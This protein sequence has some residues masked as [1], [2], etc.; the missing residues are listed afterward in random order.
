MENKTIGCIRYFGTDVKPKYDFDESI[1]SEEIEKDLIDFS[2]SNTCQVFFVNQVMND[3]VEAVFVDCG[4]VVR[5]TFPYF[6]EK[7]T[8][9]KFLEMF[10]QK[11]EPDEKHD[12]N[13]PK[14]SLVLEIEDD[15]DIMKE[16][17]NVLGK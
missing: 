12:V 3:D 4:I 17:E 5:L 15:D 6:Y 10:G 13:A 16:V 9:D 1:W 8:I 2:K 11:L 14:K 7:I